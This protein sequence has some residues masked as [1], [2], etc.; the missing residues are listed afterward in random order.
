[1]A[2][3]NS[4]TGFNTFSI[5]KNE[6]Q[7]YSETNESS[8]SSLLFTKRRNVSIEDIAKICFYYLSNS[9]KELQLYGKDLNYEELYE[10]SV[11]LAL[12]EFLVSGNAIF[13]S[14]FV[15]TNQARDVGNMNYNPIELACQIVQ[16]KKD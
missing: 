10:N 12:P 4:E 6:P 7:K 5:S 9:D 3:Q 15:T 8:E 2:S 1:M 14:D 16:N 11:D 13:F